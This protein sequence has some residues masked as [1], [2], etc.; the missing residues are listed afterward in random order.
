MASSKN[1]EDFELIYADDIEA[2]ESSERLLETI[3]KTPTA[4]MTPQYIAA[5]GLKLKAME[6]L[7]KLKEGKADDS[8]PI[9]QRVYEELTKKD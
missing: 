6:L 4:S 7:K 3:I 8:D 2:D 1:D 5:M 9:L